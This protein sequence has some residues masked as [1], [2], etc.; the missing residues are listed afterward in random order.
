MIKFAQANAIL[1]GRSVVST[2]DLYPLADCLWDKPED[3]AVI[4]SEIAAMVSP[5]LMKAVEL[6]DTAAE[7]FSQVDLINITVDDI[8]PMAEANKAL[9]QCL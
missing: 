5:D 8:K 3:R 9:M 1:N 4:F 2:N 7:L 6:R